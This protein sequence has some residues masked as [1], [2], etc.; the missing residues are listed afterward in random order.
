MEKSIL[1]TGA[2]GF[3]GR[4]VVDALVQRGYRVT[5][6]DIKAPDALNPDVEYY[7]A[8]LLSPESLVKLPKKFD[9][10]IHLAAITIPSEF[11]SSVPV[12]GNIGMTM[13]LL[14]HLEDTKIILVSSCHVY[15]SSN[16]ALLEE[17][18]LVPN[19]KYGLSK[20]LC[21][22]LV[23]FYSKR[24]T[25]ITVRPFN[26][27]GSGMPS[28]L[29]IPSLIKRVK[30]HPRNENVPLV[31][32]GYNSVRDFIDVRDVVAAYIALMEHDALENRIY[33]VCTGVGTSILHVVENVMELVGLEC[34][35]VFENQATSRDDVS[36]IIGSSGRIQ[37]ETTWRPKYS[38]RESLIDLVKHN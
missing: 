24:N 33:N 22:Q 3:V 16:S 35:I 38:L 28:S 12:V 30:E 21:E 26:H 8:D 14:E 4:Y 34:R 25:I 32:T 36:T 11:K 10:A 6:L 5:I 7:Q 17:S 27:I 37:K 18:M 19:G 13:N 29:M 20:L 2:D 1:V 15:G 23:S 31:M 9:F